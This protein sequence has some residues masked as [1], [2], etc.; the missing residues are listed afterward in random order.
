MAKKF[1]IYALKCPIDGKIRY[2]GK[3]ANFKQRFKDHLK[4]VGSSTSKKVWIDTLLKK[5]LKPI[6]IILDESDSE[7]TA[8]ILENENC[9]KHIKTVYNIFMPG[10]NTPTV[11]DYRVINNIQTD[12]GVNVKSSNSTKFDKL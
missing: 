9:I 12:L 7:D 1:K 2:V 3:S 5:G 11:N 8:R 4:D 10:K 6:L